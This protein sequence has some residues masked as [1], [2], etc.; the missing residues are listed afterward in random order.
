MRTQEL[1]VPQKVEFEKE[2][3]TERYGR[4]VAEPFERG[5]GHTIGNSLRRILLSS[6]EGAAVT[7]VRIPGA[8]RPTATPRRPGR[9]GLTIGLPS[10]RAT[11]PE[12]YRLHGTDCFG[13]TKR[14]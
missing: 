2:K 13:L 9:T 5:Y 10:V 6:L 8:P 12:S 11:A 3:V 4:F 7:A 14:T 1:I